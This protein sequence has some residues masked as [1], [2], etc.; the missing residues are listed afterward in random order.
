[1]WR[2][3]SPWTRFYIAWATLLILLIGGPGVYALYVL[4]NE[5]CHCEPG[6]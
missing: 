3:L 4:W 2:R 6:G 5:P 1:M